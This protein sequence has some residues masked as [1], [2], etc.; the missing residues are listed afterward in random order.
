[1]ASVSVLQ[2]RPIPYS[3]DTEKTSPDGLLCYDFLLGNCSISEGPILE[4]KGYA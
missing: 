4:E 3:R 1:M 2:G